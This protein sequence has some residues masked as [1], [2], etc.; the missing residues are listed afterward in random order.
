MELA[1]GA[2]EPTQ[3]QLLVFSLTHRSLEGPAALFAR[4]VGLKDL[5]VLLAWLSVLGPKRRLRLWKR[6]PE[7]LARLARLRLPGFLPPSER[8][9]EADM[10]TVATE[11]AVVALLHQ[12]DG[13]APD[14]AVST[15]LLYATLS[16]QDRQLAG[17][18]AN[19]C[20]HQAAQTKMLSARCAECTGEISQRSLLSGGSLTMEV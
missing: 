20:I 7:T 9:Q 1:D 10:P 13:P 2:P 11:A 15:Q 3:E 4:A 19:G 14:M 5:D 6:I 12:E 8:R 16:A 18:W 17:T